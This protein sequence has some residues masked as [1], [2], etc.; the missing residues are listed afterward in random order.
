MIV[1]VLYIVVAAIITYGLVIGAHMFTH[2]DVKYDFPWPI[3]S[4]IFWPIASPIAAAYIAAL[5]Y[6]KTHR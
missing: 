6:L 1:V 2:W 5:W 3:V 4:G